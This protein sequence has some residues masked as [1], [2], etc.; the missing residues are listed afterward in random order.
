MPAPPPHN[1]REAGTDWET[2]QPERLDGRA[3]AHQCALK[4]AG[5]VSQERGRTDIPTYGPGEQISGTRW[6]LQWHRHAGRCCYARAVHSGGT[7]RGH[8]GAGDS[9]TAGT[10]TAPLR[11]ARGEAPLRAHRPRDPGRDRSGR[12]SSRTLLARASARTI[13]DAIKINEVEVRPVTLNGV[14]TTV[15]TTHKAELKMTDCDRGIH[16]GQRPVRLRRLQIDYREVVAA[17][18]ETTRWSIN[19]GRETRRY[20]IGIRLADPAEAERATRSYST[21]R[22]PVG[23]GEHPLSIK[24]PTFDDNGA[25]YCPGVNAPALAGPGGH[26]FPRRRGPRALRRPIER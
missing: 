7:V 23:L 18:E 5:L 8:G 24:R 15:S 17:A 21:A 11:T 12:R 6:Q 22:R 26:S 4:D 13:Q 9:T 3:S 20:R 25:T 16:R 10:R 2:A 14:L 1:P 19:T